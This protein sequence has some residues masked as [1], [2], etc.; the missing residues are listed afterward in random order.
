MDTMLTEIHTQKV[1]RSVE[2]GYGQLSPQ[3]QNTINAIAKARLSSFRTLLVFYAS[4][5]LSISHSKDLSIFSIE[6]PLSIVL[7][8]VGDE[9]WDVMHNYDNNIPSQ[10]F[11]NSLVGNKTEELVQYLELVFTFSLFFHCSS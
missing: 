1:T 11:D 7:V 9:P 2:T 6:Y 10:A 5:D 4:G 8:G 3:E